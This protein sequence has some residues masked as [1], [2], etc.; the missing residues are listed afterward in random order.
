MFLW[1]HKENINTFGLKK[2]SYLKLCCNRLCPKKKGLAF[3]ED[4][5]HKCQTKIIIRMLLL[6]FLSNMLSIHHHSLAS[7]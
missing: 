2:A 3:L 6:N 5:L 4:N 1:R 7:Q